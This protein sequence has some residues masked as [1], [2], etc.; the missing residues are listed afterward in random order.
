MTAVPRDQATGG[1]DSGRADRERREGR[2]NALV[3]EGASPD[4]G[5]GHDGNAG[6]DEKVEV[7][8][9]DGAHPP[10]A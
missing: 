7:L 5:Q 1:R 3:H 6:A 4:R 8:G 9:P 10:R 2:Q